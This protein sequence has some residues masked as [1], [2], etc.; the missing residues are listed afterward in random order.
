LPVALPLGTRS[1]RPRLYPHGGPE[2]RRPTGLPRSCCCLR[3][4]R[5]KVALGR[6][7]ERQAAGARE[8]AGAGSRRALADRGRGALRRAVAAR[9][10]RAVA[11]RR[12]RARAAR[13]PPARAARPAPAVW[14]VALCGRTT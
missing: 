1:V 7:A 11:A 2:C 13:R 14:P 8:A 3:V 9:R 4:L 10:R 5:R 12:R 6:V